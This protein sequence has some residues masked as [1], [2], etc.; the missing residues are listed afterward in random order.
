[1]TPRVEIVP[2]AAA[3]IPALSGIESACFSVPWSAEALAGTLASPFAHVRLARRAGEPVGYLC[4]TVLAGEAEILRIAVLPA[5]R[6]Q[7]IARALLHD[8][9]KT[10]PADATFLEVRASNTAARA[11]YAAEGFRETGVRKNYYQRPA[12][13]AVCMR[14]EG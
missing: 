11:L 4:A 13:D 10:V 12:E 2:A 1:M 3:D 7:G 6:R 8:F 14:R 9:W 5:A